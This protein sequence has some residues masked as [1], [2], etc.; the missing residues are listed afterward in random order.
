M[1]GRSIKIATVAGIPIGIS[2]WWLAMVALI[3]WLPGE[4][5]FPDAVEGIAPATAYAM[6]LASALLLFA[7]VL[8]HEIGHALVARRYGIVVEEIDLWLLGGVAKLR[9]EAHVP[10]HELRYALAGPAVT[11]VLVA[12]LALVFVA[13]GAPTDT[14]VGA[15][16]EYQLIVNAM[17]LAFNLLP[18]FP[19][20]GGRVLRALLWRRSG[21]ML[22]ATATASA[23]GRA[24]G[25]GLLALGGLEVV[26]GGGPG[27]L[28]LALVGLFLVLSASSQQVAAEVRAVFSGVPAHDLMA[29]PVAVLPAGI[30]I[31]CA[32]ADYCSQHRYSA[33]PAIDVDGR[34]VGIVTL[35]AIE[36]LPMIERA[37]RTVGDLADRDPELVLREHDDVAELLERPAFGR[38]GRAVVVD[39]RGRPIGI[40]SIT[41]VRRAVRAA[42]LTRAPTGKAL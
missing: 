7:G 31:D 36:R 2:P 32:V 3:S 4:S 41:D 26:V 15:L 11:A 18:A 22:R 39:A 28:W 19:L 5:W 9:G 13:A 33:F 35:D 29:T 20:D 34:H 21:D 30:S 6:G 24:F 17:I 23:V 38:V 37:H 8:A 14:I 42:R 16:L 1:T 12:L 27:G 25:Y 40:V 10:E